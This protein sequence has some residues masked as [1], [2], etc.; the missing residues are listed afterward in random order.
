M[1]LT[2][3]AVQ[4]GIGLIQG[5]IGIAQGISDNNRLNRLLKQREAYKTPELTNQ[6]FQIAQN[7]AESGYGADTLNY[8]K[9]QTDNALTNS[10]DTATKLGAN[11]NDISSIFSRNVDAIMKTASDSELAKVTKFDKLY[12]SIANVA[13]GQDAEFADRR[14][15][16]D[17]Q[18]AAAG[19][20]VKAG[21]DTLKSGLGNIAGA[22]TNYATSQIGNPDNTVSPVM[23][24]V[25]TIPVANAASTVGKTVTG[26]PLGGASVIGNNINGTPSFNNYSD[27]LKWWD[28]QGSKNF[29]I[30]S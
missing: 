23:G 28:T 9:S 21:N 8:I 11:P 2:A 22:F 18:M 29:N 4:G 25:N 3:A 7:Q 24:G 19:M 17:D 26:A 13:A 6:Q 14:A 12:T 5:G 30:N 20:K 15:K 16:N 10:L 27:L 1:P